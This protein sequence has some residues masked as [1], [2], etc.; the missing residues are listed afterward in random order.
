MLK[1]DFGAYEGVKAK[2][3]LSFFIYNDFKWGI[4]AALQKGAVEIF[5]NFWR[6]N[7]KWGLVIQKLWFERKLT[8]VY[9]NFG[10]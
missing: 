2:D 1:F 10:Q 8:F 9:C 7:L 6:S 5:A 3:N 4:M